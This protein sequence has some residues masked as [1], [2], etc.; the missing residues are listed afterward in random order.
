[1]YAEASGIEVVEGIADF[2][3][4]VRDWIRLEHYGYP[5]HYEFVGQALS[6]I[7]LQT[8]QAEQA[9]ASDGD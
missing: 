2:L 7:T 6:K 5:V 1:M 3:G 4:T 9:G 8:K